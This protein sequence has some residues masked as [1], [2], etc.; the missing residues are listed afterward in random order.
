MTVLRNFICGITNIV[1]LDIPSLIDSTW[2][3]LDYLV[4]REHDYRSRHVELRPLITPPFWFFALLLVFIS[5]GPTGS[6]LCTAIP[7]PALSF[8]RGLLA[9]MISGLTVWFAWYYRQGPSNLVA[10]RFKRYGQSYSKV[11]RF[12]VKAAAYTVPGFVLVAFVGG[13]YTFLYAWPDCTGAAFNPW[14]LYSLLLC[15]VVIAVCGIIGSRLSQA[16]TIVWGKPRAPY[17]H[18]TVRLM[19]MQ[20]AVIVAVAVIHWCFLADPFVREADH[21]PYRHVFGFWAPAIVCVLIAAPLV[22]RFMLPDVKLALTQPSGPTGPPGPSPSSNFG[23]DAAKPDPDDISIE[24]QQFRGWLKHTEL[25]EARS[26]PVLSGRRLFFAAVYGPFYHVLHLLL[27]PALV[28]LVV[29]AKWLYLYVSVALLFSALLLMWGHVAARWDEMNVQVERWFLRG[30]PLFVS[31]LVILLA[32]CRVVQFDYISTILDALPFGTIFGTIVMT[33]VLFWFMEYWLNRIVGVR[34]LRVLG[35]GNDEL[36][37]S[38]S[39]EGTVPA[40]I[41]VEKDG[42]FL[43]LHGTGR[44]VVVGEPLPGVTEPVAFNTFGFLNLFTRLSEQAQKPEERFHV[45]DIERRLSSYFFS[46][47]FVMLA[48]TAGF[49]VYYARNHLYSNNGM[50]PVLET[51][52]SGQLAGSVRLGDLLIAKPGQTSPAVVVVGSGGG[53]RAALYTASVLHGLHGL[54]VDKD[55]VLLSGV[56]GGG[57]ALAYFAAN[58]DALVAPRGR[59]DACPA[60]FA[61]G[62]QSAGNWNCFNDGMTKPFIQ[63][64]LNGAT[65]WRL[66][67]RTALSRLLAESF[68]KRLFG[69]RK[70]ASITNPG[71]IL[72]ATVV[73]HPAD[74]SELLKGTLSEPDVTLPQDEQCMEAERTFQMLSGGRMVFTNLRDT[75]RFP[76]GQGRIPDVRLPYRII[77]TEDVPLATAAALNANFPP[78]FPSARVRVLDAAAGNCSARSFYATDGGAVENLGLISALYALQSAVDQIDANTTLRPIHIVLAEASAVTYD[79]GQDRGLSA[80]S[81]SRERLAGGLTETLISS[82]ENAIHS[83]NATNP[84]LQFYYLGLPLAFRARGGFGTHW[85]YA[86][87][88]HLSDPRPRSVSWKDYIP[89]AVLRDAKAAVDHKALSQL[90]LAL[91]HRERDFCSVVFEG[92]SKKVQSWICGDLNSHPEGQDQHMRQWKRLRDQLGPKVA[93]K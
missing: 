40:D 66:F 85:M 33:Y 81:G 38:Y 62:S 10:R 41:R 91:H 11:R 1:F 39:R 44:F 73:S 54:G 65:E 35:Q 42:R 89:S 93:G 69:N 50:D 37:A 55:I 13:A 24:A 53:T 26:E 58:R 3:R 4:N 14:S 67:S 8:T 47:N 63:D 20:V 36:S 22:A 78:V 56:S 92:E 21:V 64:V 27:P 71:L 31:A 25:F 84:D 57:A 45:K 30:G 48:I 68:E 12:F 87:Q 46:L 77:R 80:L 60:D 5:Y 9:V 15:L 49:I 43:A 28:A 52:S 75:E 2:R 88:Y 16:R 83:K 18:L 19:F 70:V 29:E 23:G 90:W 7:G 86:D 79:Y 17:A 82:L 61:P 34:L 32:I 59:D 51:R 72:N 6:G 74:A 76:S